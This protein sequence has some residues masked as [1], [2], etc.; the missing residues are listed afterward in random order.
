MESWVSDEVPFKNVQLIS[1][2]SPE[3]TLQDF[4]NSGA[5]RATVAI[6]FSLDNPVGTGDQRIAESA[7]APGL[8]GLLF[9]NPSLPATHELAGDFTVAVL[10]DGDVTT[11]RGWPRERW[12]SSPLLFWDQ[13]SK[14]GRLDNEPAKRG[15]VG[16]VCLRREIAPGASADFTFVL[17]WRFPNRTPKRMGWTAPKGLEETVVG[18]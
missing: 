9:T 11:W 5:E 8:R 12:F 17:A 13:F 15:P 14:Q 6:A 16:S 10:G 7:E 1:N 2:G 3:L 18:N 4:G